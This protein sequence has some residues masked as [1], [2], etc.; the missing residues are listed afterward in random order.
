M[1][2]AREI[3]ASIGLALA[4][5]ALALLLL[6]LGLRV[7]ASFDRNQFIALMDQPRVEEGRPLF[8]WDLI[9]SHPDDRVVYELRPGTR[10]RFRGHDLEINSLGMRGEEVSAERPDG[11]FRILVLGDS[12][13]FGWGMA[14]DAAFPAVVEKLLESRPAV[15]RVEV[16]NSGIPGY[17]AVQ[18]VR[19]F[20]L[21]SDELAPDLVLITFVH[22]D[23]D[24]PNFLADPPDVWDLRT[25]FL[26]TLVQR[27]AALLQGFHLAPGWMVGVPVDPRDRYRL[28]KSR[29]P[30]RYR[31][32]QGWDN[33]VAAY[34]RLA[35]LAADRGIPHAVVFS[36]NDYGPRL[37]G[38]VDDVLP[39]HVRELAALLEREGFLVI[40]PQERIVRH[41]RRR[42]ISHEGLWLE[43]DDKHP[44]A[45]R[46]RLLAEE[47][48]ARLDGAGLL[49]RDATNAATGR[50]PA[51][52]R[53]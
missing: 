37:D 10:G 24:L 19:T 32:L 49:P 47:I 42:G 16:L 11:T 50:E 17:N 12:H 6:E 26:A 41:L 8:L 43:S 7:A 53:Q 36:W 44:S 35:R 23:M 28:P 45:L 22:N 1:T 39:P 51:G 30:E 38:R 4:S 25:S 34:R 14:Q 9:R 48:V 52:P 27:R 21:R 13:A 18:E 15:P 31:P 46:H 33:M 40:D 2:R 29:I 20:E 5:V 3:A